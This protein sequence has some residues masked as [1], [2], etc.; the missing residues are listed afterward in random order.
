MEIEQI[1]SQVPVLTS[2]FIFTEDVLTQLLDTRNSVAILVA[3]IIATPKN[4]TIT[5]VKGK[6]IKKVTAVKPK[7][8]AGYKLKKWPT[9]WESVG[10]ANLA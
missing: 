3:R 9:D 6:L 5:C 8:P 10:C 2:E 1:Q 7:C 4:S